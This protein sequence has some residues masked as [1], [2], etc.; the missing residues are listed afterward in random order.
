[1]IST[2]YLYVIVCTGSGCSTT[3][4][5][6]RDLQTCERFAA[7]FRPAFPPHTTENE[8]SFAVFCAGPEEWKSTDQNW[9]RGKQP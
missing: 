5:P 9:N 3:R 2:I 6:M 1:M 7:T 8:S 4:H